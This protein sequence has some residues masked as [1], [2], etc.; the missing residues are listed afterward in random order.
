MMMVMSATMMTKASP[1]PAIRCGEPEDIMNGILERKCQ[2]PI[3]INI[4]ISSIIITLESD[5]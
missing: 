3:I 5:R 4:I 1:T 2:V